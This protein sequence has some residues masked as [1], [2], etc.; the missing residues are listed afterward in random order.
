LSKQLSSKLKTATEVRHRVQYAYS[1]PHLQEED[2][3]EG[4]ASPPVAQRAVINIPSS[5]ANPLS[6][7]TPI[8]SHLNL[9]S[10]L[11]IPSNCRKTFLRGSC[12]SG[13]TAEGQSLQILQAP[14]PYS[15]FRSR[16]KRTESSDCRCGSKVLEICIEYMLPC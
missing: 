12:Q 11:E 10:C 5:P 15:I 6:F 8:I 3:R 14:I 16:Q 4:S 9:T 1:E 2:T 7:P 13:I